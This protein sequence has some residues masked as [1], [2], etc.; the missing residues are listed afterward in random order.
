MAIKATESC[1]VEGL[2]RTPFQIRQLDTRLHAK[3]VKDTRCGSNTQIGMKTSAGTLFYCTNTMHIFVK[4]HEVYLG[5]G[6]IH[7]AMY[8]NLDNEDTQDPF[9][10]FR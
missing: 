7:L 5:T 4:E 3:D 6:D 2:K 9:E 1:C 10:L 8:V